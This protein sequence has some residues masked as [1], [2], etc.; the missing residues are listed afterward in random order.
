MACRTGIEHRVRVN[1]SSPQPAHITILGIGMASVTGG[2]GRHVRDGFSLWSLATEN[3]G[4]GMASGACPR[5]E[6]MDVTGSRPADISRF[7]IGMAGIAG[8]CC[9]HVARI[10]ASRCRAVVASRTKTRIGI[11]WNVELGTEEFGVVGRVG[12]VMAGIASRRCW[13]MGG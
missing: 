8:S 3:C 12:D 11:G 10:L 6:S 13:N 7:Y 9:R 4:S 1:V 2:R 5:W